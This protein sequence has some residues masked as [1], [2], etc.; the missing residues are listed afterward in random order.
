MSQNSSHENVRRATIRDVAERANVSASA[1]SLT[2]AGRG[3]IS[4][5][6]RQRIFQ[7][8]AAL[9]YKLP[10]RNRASADRRDFTVESGKQLTH[11][12]EYVQL[13]ME[14]RRQE[15]CDVAALEPS[16]ERLIAY[17]TMDEAESLCARLEHIPIRPDFPYI[18]PSE[19]DEI[20]DELP[21]SD[22]VGQGVY[23]SAEQLFDRVY[24]GWLGR[25]AGCML[26]K[27]LELIG[28]LED[29][30]EFLRRGG[31]YPL[32][33]YVPEILPYPPIFAQRLPHITDTLLGQINGA[34][35]DDDLDYTVLNLRIL[36]EHGAA[37][38][39]EHIAHSWLH[40]LA[41]NTV[42]TA[43]C[44][45]YANL[46][47]HFA[48]PETAVY[49][50]PFREFI[51]AQI[52]ADIFG[53]SAPGQPLVAAER[54]WRDARLSHVKNGLYGAMMTA[55]MIAVAFTTNDVEEII[56][57]GLQSIPARS[58]LS[59]AVQ[60]TL[61]QTR[62]AQSWRTAAADITERFVDYDPVHV[63]PNACF[64]VLALMW[65]RG[66]FEEAI[67]TAAMCGLDTDCNAATVGSIIGIIEGASALP[68]KWIK[69]LDDRLES[70]VRGESSNRISDL[71]QRTMAVIRALGI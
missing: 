28:T 24:G 55:A 9:D 56:Y 19:W 40:H 57:A 58:R 14:Q 45:A 7:A 65:S 13:E 17:P 62:S 42:Y 5:E 22:K 3:R 36:E 16:L 21:E 31:A 44:V 51:G 64:V 33:N 29:V 47:Q 15:G 70:W 27:P 30:E 1:V 8:A 63:I 68:P 26:G 69:P 46:I 41:Y 61:E 59:E 38:R 35:R 32:D 53:Y 6:T 10:R 43:E 25:C 23:F 39:T 34:V 48:P 50:N 4:D 71:A 54:A 11:L 2:L 66:D 20:L 49:R 52:R 37:F 12:L 60:V 18:E 67:T